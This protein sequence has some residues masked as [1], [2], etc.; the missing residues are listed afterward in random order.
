MQTPWAD[1]IIRGLQNLHFYFLLFV[2]VS[3]TFTSATSTFIFLLNCEQNALGYILKICEC[4]TRCTHSSNIWTTLLYAVV[5]FLFMSNIENQFFLH[6]VIILPITFE[7]VHLADG[8]KYQCQSLSTESDLWSHHYKC[9]QVLVGN[10]NEAHVS[11]ARPV[12]LCQVVTVCVIT[13]FRLL[14]LDAGP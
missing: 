9:C 14:A 1:S 7:V 8:L 11:F 10:K 4:D 3:I 6:A 13:N 5:Q 12:W 2:L